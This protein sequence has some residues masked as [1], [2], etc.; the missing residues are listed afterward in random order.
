MAGNANFVIENMLA[1]WEAQPM[2]VVGDAFGHATPVGV[3]VPQG[4]VTND[5]LSRTTS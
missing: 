3:P 4:R 2:I 1:G 5:A